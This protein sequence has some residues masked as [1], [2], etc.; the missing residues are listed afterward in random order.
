LA[1]RVRGNAKEK[2]EQGNQEV[3]MNGLATIDVEK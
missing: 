2:E 3:Q 1:G